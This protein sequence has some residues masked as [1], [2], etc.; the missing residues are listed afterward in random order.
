MRLRARHYRTAQPLDVVCEQGKITRL[1]A[2]STQGADHVHEWLAPACSDVQINGC[3][4]ISFNAD[5]LTQ[6]QIQHVVRTCRAHGIAQLCPTLVTGSFDALAH[7]FRTLHA[8]CEAD[9]FLA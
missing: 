2:V 4:G 7:G 5:S 6:G 1:D 8:A 3:D 9:A